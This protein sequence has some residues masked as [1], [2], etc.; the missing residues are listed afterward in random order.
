MVTIGEDC[1]EN[2]EAFFLNE[3][4]WGLCPGKNDSTERLHRPGA[5]EVF[6]AAG[7][8]YSEK[9]GF[10]RKPASGQDVTE[11][12]N[13]EDVSRLNG[14]TG[15]NL[16]IFKAGFFQNKAKTGIIDL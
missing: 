4:G 13:G 14:R 15:K 8:V 3:N 5:D 6:F 12:G 16:Q 1:Q 11:A 7:C 9:K 2:P 10:L